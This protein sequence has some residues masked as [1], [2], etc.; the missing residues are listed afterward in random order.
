MGYFL[1][2]IFVGIPLIEI[3]VFIRVGGLIGLWPT[4]AI[5][6]LTA[7]LGSWLL[8]MQGLKTLVSAQQSFERGEM[9]V[10][11]LFDGLCLLIA[12]AL[13]LTPGF[14]TDTIGFLLFIPPVRVFLVG[15]GWRFLQSRGHV[16]TWSSRSGPSPRPGG[17]DGGPV[18]DGEFKEVD[19]AD[20]SPPDE[21]DKIEPR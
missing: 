12:G 7:A 14:V 15:Y 16:H 1:F 10:A 8:R 4:I 17:K 2:A 9:P 20:R 19:G 6:I 13:L 21:H 18:I 5:V 11:E 3:A